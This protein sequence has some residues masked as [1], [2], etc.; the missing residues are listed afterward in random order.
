MRNLML[1]AI[2]GVLGI[3]GI[4]YRRA[5][6]IESKNPVIPP[7]PLRKGIESASPDWVF[8]KENGLCPQFELLAREME[9]LGE[10]AS[11]LLL[12]KV[13]L[14]LFH[15]CGAQYDFIKSESAEFDK[16]AGRMFSDG[17]VEI[18][19]AVKNTVA[20]TVAGMLTDEPDK[21][22]RLLTIKATGVTVEV[23]SG[24]AKTDK[25]AAFQFD[26]GHG[27][28]VGAS[29]DPATR[30]LEL[31]SE[32]H[33]TWNGKD[34]KQKPMNLEAGTLI[35]KEVESKVYLSP[36]A[37]LK[38]DTLTLESENADVSLESGAIRLV[39]AVKAHGTDKF[40]N[41]ELSFGAEE[42]TMNLTAKS[43]IEKIT[44]TGKAKLDAVSA[45]ART[46]VAT[47]RIDL[48]F[49]VTEEGSLLRTATANGHSVVE[50]KPTAPT[51]ATR[52]LKAET[53]VTKMRAN[54]EEIDSME[55]HSPGTLD[56]IPNAPGQP[57]RHLDAERMSM[58]YGD[59]NQLKSFRAVKTA[60]D[61][62]KP[63]Q[64]KMKADAPPALTWSQDLTAEFH[65]VSGELTK[66]DQWGG[67]RYKE[68][69]R[70]AKAEHA[71]LDA[72]TNLITLTRSN[73]EAA[74]AWDPTGSVTADKIVM[75]QDTGDFTADG[76]VSSTRLPDK[77]KPDADAPKQNAM[78]APDEAMQATADR[79]TSTE[80]NKRLV[81][82]GNAML[83][84][85]ANRLQANRVLI[86]RTGK[87]LIAEGNVVSQFLDKKPHPRTKR[88]VNTVVRSEKLEYRDSERL[89][90]YTGGARMIRDDM[91]VKSKEIRA[92]LVE[93]SKGDSSLDRAF[94]DGA[95]EIFQAS[96]DRTRRG[97]SEHAEYYVTGEKLILN[98]GIAQMIDSVDG[99]TRGKQL[100][101]LAGNDTLQ[102]EGA[103]TQPVVSRIR[104]K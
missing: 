27:D 16:A 4:Q 36:W 5:K 33:L 77:K 9:S 82:E 26:L 42:M 46:N 58:A 76:K 100:T 67:F 57:R 93:D 28:A 55:T 52:V 69:E 59:K 60:T 6:A 15:K 71:T 74:R 102:V 34:P 35:Y 13:Q 51:Q 48:D 79:M 29:Y 89:A 14:R 19:L 22:G 31:L 65:P 1:L 47:D 90:H 63:R 41:R 12:K 97:S 49:A 85:T 66:L 8:R 43:E 54:G 91:D 98:G 94:A 95:V 81:Y 101:Y 30:E 86:D 61:T 25:K 21:P 2:L 50:S 10:P 37:K 45:T 40:P 88:V 70:E 68:G 72:P 3:V 56:L 96:P 99:T 38:R 20:G 83:W 78:L 39:N 87:M 84:Q 32:V 64:A 18:T 24:K 73:E 92:W 62:R 75:H 11:K 103:I 104:R 23:E 7:T 53:I 80:G 44:G 17:E